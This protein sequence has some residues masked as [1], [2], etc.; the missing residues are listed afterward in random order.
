MGRRAAT[1]VGAAAAASVAVAALA[2]TAL[3]A[4]RTATFSGWAAQTLALSD[5]RLV[6]H[7]TAPV[8]VDP[9]NFPE[10]PRGAVRFTYYRAEAK[11][12]ALT[13]SRLQFE[14]APETITSVRTSIGAMRPDILWPA[15]EGRFVM[16]PT[17]VGLRFPTP[18]IWCCTD[19]IEVVTES[20]SR[21]EAGRAVAAAADPAGR[22]RM[23]LIDPAGAASL[24]AVDPVGLGENR[25]GV[26]V[27]V[28]TRPHLAAMTATQL[29]WVDPAAPSLLRRATVTDAG[30]GPVSEVVLPGAA[31]R[32]RAGEGTAVVVVRLAPG[33][34]RVLRVDAAAA[35]PRSLWNGRAVPRVAAGGGTVAI[36]DGRRILTQRRTGRTRR[37]A[38]AA[39][40]VPALAADGTRVA[41]L[42]R[43]V[44]QRQ[45]VTVARLVAVP[46]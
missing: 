26:P 39:G 22:V 45:R 15:G 28:A 1:L 14:G 5:E 35:R 32:V 30:L 42:Q 6:V 17:A 24:V 20:D 21:A 3:G 43:G 4:A 16:A 36:A 37:V 23:L 46:R 10:A 41:W 33:R 12:V 18:V 27:A 19:G 44:R 40:V 29:V 34:H 25:V 38:T 2:P 8:V 7:E 11:A 9:R 31:V 13:R